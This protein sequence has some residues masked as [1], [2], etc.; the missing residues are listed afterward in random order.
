MPAYILIMWWTE[1][2]TVLGVERAAS[3][4]NH[5]VAVTGYPAAATRCDLHN[6]GQTRS[7]CAVRG[8]VPPHHLAG[9]IG[10]V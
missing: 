7:N 6:N 8:S 1:A 5:G 10:V 4:C 9:M 2:V 3:T